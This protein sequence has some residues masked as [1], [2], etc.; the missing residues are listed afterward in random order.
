MFKKRIL[1]GAQQPI[2]FEKAKF[3]GHFTFEC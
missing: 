1:V 2:A 3:T